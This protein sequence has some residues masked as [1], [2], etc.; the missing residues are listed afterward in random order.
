ML[1]LEESDM[2]KWHGQLLTNASHCKFQN[3]DYPER[4]LSKVFTI[5]TFM[6]NDNSRLMVALVNNLAKS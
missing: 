6:S 2:R 4:K 3:S 5:L 1:T